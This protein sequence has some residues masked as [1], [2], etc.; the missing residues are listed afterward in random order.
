MRQCLA[1]HRNRIPHP[2][3]QSHFQACHS[4][5]RTLGF[6]VLR[7]SQP[8]TTGRDPAFLPT[9]VLGKTAFKPWSDTLDPDPQSLGLT[10]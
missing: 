4:G 9:P 2:R 10:P 3:Q 7:E 8:R 6:S 5:P 1:G